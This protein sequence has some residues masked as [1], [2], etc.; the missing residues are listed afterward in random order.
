L[1]IC[2]IDLKNLGIPEDG[3]PD[4]V[5][6]VPLATVSIHMLERKTLMRRVGFQ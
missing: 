2:R 3:M 4:G 6:R 5:E 1:F